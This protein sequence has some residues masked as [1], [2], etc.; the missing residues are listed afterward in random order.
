MVL[1]LSIIASATTRRIGFKRFR[2]CA[3]NRIL[4]VIVLFFVLSVVM[5]KFEVIL[6]LWVLLIM[7]LLLVFVFIVSNIVRASVRI[8]TLSRF[9]SFVRAAFRAMVKLLVMM[10]LLLLRFRV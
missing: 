6:W 5:L 10:L 4:C 2:A 3:A 1:C 8:R 9:A 7:L